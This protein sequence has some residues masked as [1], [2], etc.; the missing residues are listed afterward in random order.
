MSDFFTHSGFETQRRRHQKFKTEVAVAPK[1]WHLNVSAKIFNKTFF[2]KNSVGLLDCGNS[3]KISLLKCLTGLTG[4]TVRQ[5]DTHGQQS[6][7][8][9]V[10]Q[11][12]LDQLVDDQADTWAS[13]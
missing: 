5:F 8:F 11:K 7:S 2:F 12:V 9:E 10:Q 1:I 3:R 6:D 4:A 13:Q